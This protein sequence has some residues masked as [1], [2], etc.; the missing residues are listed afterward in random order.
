MDEIALGNAAF[1]EELLHG[2]SGVVLVLGRED[3]VH[4]GVKHEDPPFGLPL[5]KRTDAEQEQ[6]NHPVAHGNSFAFLT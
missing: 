4:A 5:G 3:D 1:G 6:D 2:A